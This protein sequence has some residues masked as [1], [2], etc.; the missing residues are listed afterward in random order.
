VEWEAESF[1]IVNVPA[2]RPPSVRRRY[3]LGW[4]IREDTVIL[5]DADTDE[6]ADVLDVLDR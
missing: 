2:R 1:G 3:R 4:P 6:D 5:D